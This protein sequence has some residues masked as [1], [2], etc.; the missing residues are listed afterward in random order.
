MKKINWQRHAQRQKNIQMTE[1]T[2]ITDEAKFNFISLITK[3]GHPNIGLHEQLGLDTSIYDHFLTDNPVR[4]KKSQ[5]LMLKLLDFGVKCGLEEAVLLQEHLLEYCTRKVFWDEDFAAQ[6]SD[7]K[8]S[9]IE[10]D[11][12]GKLAKVIDNLQHLKGDLNPRLKHLLLNLN[13]VVFLGVH[14]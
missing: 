10:Q 11:F 3:V 6:P 12:T 9:L 1:I 8:I 7:I 13:E 5:S 4:N 2:V 14:S